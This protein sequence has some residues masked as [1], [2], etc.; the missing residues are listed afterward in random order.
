LTDRKH[1]RRRYLNPL[2]ESGQLRMTMPNKPRSSLQKYIAVPA[3]QR[4]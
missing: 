1:F 2:L 3:E 4:E